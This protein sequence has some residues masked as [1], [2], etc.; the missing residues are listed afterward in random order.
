MRRIFRTPFPYVLAVFLAIRIFAQQPSQIISGSRT[1]EGGLTVLGQ[2]ATIESGSALPTCGAPTTPPRLFLLSTTNTVYACTSLGWVGITN[3]NGGPTGSTGPQ[4]PTGPQG[5]A[6]PAG[7]NGVTGATGSQGLTGPQGPA[8]SN[9]ANGSTVLNGVGAPPGSNGVTGDFYLRTD[10]DCL[11]G[12]RG[13][14]GWPGT[15]TSLLGANGNT[16]LSGVGAP[17]NASGSNG[18]F[19]IRTDTSCIYGPKAAGAWPGSCVSMLGTNGNTLLSGTSPPSSGTGSNGDFFIR[20]DTSCLYGPKASGAWPGSCTP[21]IGPQGPTGA[22]G[23]AGA[24]GTNGNTVLNGTSTPG[25]GTGNV[26]D[27]FLR[28]DTN[29]LYGPKGSGG[30]P[31][32]CVSLVGPQGPQGA[33]GANGNTLLNGTSGP[34]SGTG[35]NGDFFLRTDTSC[36]YGP[37]ATGA[38]PGSCT[39]LV[40]PQ[41]PAGANGSNGTN[42]NTVLNGTSGP[43]S[44]AGSNGDFFLR[45]DTNCLYGPKVSGSWPGSC[46]SLVGP[47]GPQ[48]ATGAAGQGFTFRGSWSALLNYAAN[49]VVTYNGSTYVAIIA[50]LNQIP[51]SSPTSWTLSVAAGAQGPP[52][53]AGAP[54][55]WSVVSFSATP[56]FNVTNP[57]QGFQITLTGTVVSS[58]VTG[59]LVQGQDVTFKICQDS[60]GGHAFP[61]PGGIVG[62]GSIATG[63]NACSMQSFRYDATNTLVA[64]GPMNYLSSGAISLSESQITNLSSDLAGKAA[65]G[66]SITV[67]GVSCILSASCSPPASSVNGTLTANMPNGSAGSQVTQTQSGNNNVSTILDPF[68][69]IYNGSLW[70]GG[71]AGNVF[72]SGHWNPGNYG[73]LVGVGYSVYQFGGHNQIQSLDKKTANAIQVRYTAAGAGQH[74]GLDVDTTCVAAGD[75]VGIRAGITPSSWSSANGDEGVVPYK[76]D[77]FGV[78]AMNNFAITAVTNNGASTTLSAG[79]PKSGSCANPATCDYRVIPLT[80]ST[81]FSAGQWIT[82]DNSPFP[83]ATVDTIQ[84]IAVSGSCGGSTLAANQICGLPQSDHLSGAPVVAAPVLA[85]NLAGSGVIVGQ[86][87]NIVDITATPVTTGNVDVTGVVNVTAHGGA[88]F[89]NTMVGGNANLPGCIAFPKTDITVS[90][91]NINDAGLNGSRLTADVVNTTI[92][93]ISVDSTLFGVYDT[94]SIGSEEMLITAIPDTTHLTVTR[95]YNGSTAATHVTNDWV[96]LDTRMWYPIAATSAGNATLGAPF[97]F[98]D[99][100]VNYVLGQ[101]SLTATDYVVRPCGFVGALDVAYNTSAN[102]P[103]MTENAVVI[104]GGAGYGWGSGHVLRQTVP[105]ASVEAVGMQAA[106]Q[107]WNWFPTTNV[108]PVFRSL[109]NGRVRLQSAFQVESSAFADSD[110]TAGYDNGLFI[111]GNTAKSSIS[112]ISRDL[113]GRGLSFA[114]FAAGAGVIDHKQISWGGGGGAALIYPDGSE[115]VIDSVGAGLAKVL[116]ANTGSNGSLLINYNNLTNARTWNVQDA[117]GSVALILPGYIGPQTLTGSIGDTVEFGHWTAGVVSGN[118]TVDVTDC[119]VDNASVHYQFA[120]AYADGQDGVWRTIAPKVQSPANMSTAAWALDGMIEVGTGYLHL[121]ARRTAAG[122]S[123]SLYPTLNDVE[124]L[125]PVANTWVYSGATASGVSAPTQAWLSAVTTDAGNKLLITNASNIALT[126]DPTNETAAHT[127]FSPNLGGTLALTGAAQN[128][129][130]GTVSSSGG[131]NIVYRCSVAGTL[132]LGQLTTVSG[133]CGTAVDTGMRVN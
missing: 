67:N 74:A 117:S 5:T 42:G 121:R 30:W 7:V 20:T 52:G 32:T 106:V 39:P 29:C 127:I 47:T 28:T 88:N 85:S 84:I 76:A 95:G 11:Y 79:I 68:S 99:L 126:I 13:T 36:L 19:F 43:S 107:T 58:T 16:V 83:S 75:C 125:S 12:P 4:G 110:T 78:T 89:T 98:V 3:P 61:A 122:S 34:S 90:L 49:D 15:C 116:L 86:D 44:G 123:L 118:I 41:G 96:I 51:A 72:Q 1:I 81:G 17:N 114:T 59:T 27:F 69:T 26:G 40:G 21:L 104:H 62:F 128:V 97:Q 82:I 56:V 57:L 113:S 131:A 77:I 91:A 80:S 120:T 103:T 37:K 71:I 23:A 73:N 92:A 8:G 53:P 25:G 24:N 101:Q 102:P 119:C 35:N 70:Q 48:G 112:A 94:V 38:W 93:S 109:N 60:V 87:K 31:G 115:F 9:G 55:I 2:T 6:G 46:V 50:S 54:P 111:N 133:D 130:F 129:V 64:V 18:D 63:G 10:T 66:A 65:S 100:T 22:A 105:P 124:P 14:G 33:A 108:T 45:T 132:R